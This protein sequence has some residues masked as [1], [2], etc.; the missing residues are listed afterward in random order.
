M[1]KLMCTLASSIL[2]LSSGLAL[3]ASSTD[4]VNYPTRPITI[5]VPFSPGTGVDLVARLV[6][7]K[8]Q[9]RWGQPAVVENRTGV[10]GHL[11]AQLVAQAP[12]DGHTLLVTTSNIMITASLFPSALFDA[13]KDL[14]PLTVATW[15]NATLTTVPTA[16]FKTVDELIAAAK[17]NP[18]K[19]AF[20]TPGVG[21]PQHI[22]L[23]L[24]ER[25]TGTEFLHVPYKGMAPTMQ[26]LIGGQTD[27]MYMATHALKPH[28]EANK[29]LPIAVASDVR[30]RAIPDVP[31]FGEY[32]IKGVITDAWCG[33]L[34]PAGT[35]PAVL[36]KLGAELRAILELPDVKTRLEQ[37]GVDVRPSTA[38]EMAEVMKHEHT[39]YADIIKEIDLKV[40]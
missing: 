29:M 35:P 7:E 40:E 26:G 8:L 3:A 6:G 20:G 23:K 39:V 28:V 31:S 37:T 2:A 36:E 30:H 32:G 25:A 11:G 38:Q 18:G 17:K 21:S 9:E 14:V 4:N 34:A 12:A 5:I 10:S 19:L 16:E 33:F 27:V 1:R 24:F 22:A 15:A 13:T